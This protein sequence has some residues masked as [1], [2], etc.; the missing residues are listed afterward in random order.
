M[1]PAQI[2]KLVER[3]FATWESQGQIKLKAPRGEAIQRA[4]RAIQA[5]LDQELQI[6]DQARKIVENLEKK[7]ENF[8]RHKM[9]LMVKN[10]LAKEKNFIL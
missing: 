6:E 8:D 1:S 3:I 2:Q 7:G 10:Q 4:I 9:Y 5:N